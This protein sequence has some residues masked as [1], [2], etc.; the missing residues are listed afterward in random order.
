MAD[1][2]ALHSATTLEVSFTFLARG[3][4]RT[5][6]R[7]GQRPTRSCAKLGCKTGLEELLRFVFIIDIEDHRREEHQSLDD[8]LIVDAN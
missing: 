7:A 2:V 3:L 5:Q 6:K 4:N 1:Y 8:L